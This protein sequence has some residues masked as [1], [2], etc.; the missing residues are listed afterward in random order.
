MTLGVVWLPQ[1]LLLVWMPLFSYEA[2]STLPPCK[3]KTVASA[4]GNSLGPRWWLVI[5][6][7]IYCSL[8]LCRSDD[9]LLSVN[10]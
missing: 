5:V 7:H 10:Q 8:T 1:V 6:S 9:Y 2:M 3:A 4:L